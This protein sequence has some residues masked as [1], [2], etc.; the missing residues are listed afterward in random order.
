LVLLGLVALVPVFDPHPWTRLGRASIA[1]MA[2]AVAIQSLIVCDYAVYSGQTAG[3]FASARDLVG[4]NQRVGTLLTRTRSRFRAN[5]LLHAD[6]WLGVGTGNVIWSDYET[7]FYYFPVH[8]KPGLN[9][10][11]PRELERL[12]IAE[13]PGEQEARARDWAK[14]LDKHAEA[15]DVL[16]CWGEAPPLDAVSGRWFEPVAKL[17]ELRVL[18][19]RQ[20]QGALAH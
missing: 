19:K 3:T 14:L 10:P 6:N 1:A 12:S 20:T 13:G 17:G 7:R 15:I 5:P 18:R 8:F 11:D 16:V 4:R 2:V 9:R